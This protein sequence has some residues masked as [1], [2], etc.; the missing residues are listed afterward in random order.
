METLVEQPYNVFDIKDGQLSCH[1]L[2]AVFHI[3]SVMVPQLGSH[4]FKKESDLSLG[5]NQNKNKFRS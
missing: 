4:G 3:F 5:K 2:W 1:M